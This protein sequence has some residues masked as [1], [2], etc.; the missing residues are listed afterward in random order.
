MQI[1]SND[2]QPQLT[3]MKPDDKYFNPVPNVGTK[4]ND[5]TASIMVETGTYQFKIIS[6]KAASGNYVIKA[7][8]TD[9]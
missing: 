1:I 4:D 7:W 9:R 8:V 2:F 5:F 6:T 3:M